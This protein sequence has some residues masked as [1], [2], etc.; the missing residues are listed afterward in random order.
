[1]KEKERIGAFKETFESFV[2]NSKRRKGQNTMRMNSNDSSMKNKATNSPRAY[3]RSNMPIHD[4]MSRSKRLHFLEKRIHPLKASLREEE[5]QFLMNILLVRVLNS[6]SE[7]KITDPSWGHYFG[8]SLKAQYHNQR[9]KASTV[10]ELRS[11]NRRP[12]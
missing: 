4:G 10:I 8:L 1:M 2:A 5:G 7:V 11:P 9:I 12:L 3:S 6:A